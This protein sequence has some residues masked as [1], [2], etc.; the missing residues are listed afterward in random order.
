[1]SRALKGCLELGGG[2]KAIAI[3]IN[4]VEVRTFTHQ[5]T[6]PSEIFRKV[7]SLFIVAETCPLP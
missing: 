5:N 7:Q 3:G 6:T 4:R 1:M 2:N